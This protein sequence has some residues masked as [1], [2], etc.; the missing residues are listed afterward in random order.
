MEDQYVETALGRIR[1]R[2]AGSGPAM[3]FRS[4]LLMDGMLWAGQVPYF[5][6]RFRVILVDPRR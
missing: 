4:S 3:L 5:V 1:L 2:A 6:D